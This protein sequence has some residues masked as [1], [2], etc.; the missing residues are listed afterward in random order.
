[1]KHKKLL[2]ITLVI[3]AL[4]IGSTLPGIAYN[5]GKS[6]VQSLEVV[7]EVFD[8][9]DWVDSI[10][11]NFGDLVEFKITIT[12]H[13]VTAPGTMHWAESIVVT[14]QLPSCLD[15][16][17]CS[18]TPFEPTIVGKTLEWDLGSIKLMDGES[19]VITFN[20]TVVEYGINVNNAK[21]T[22]YEHCT[23][24][25]IQGKDTATVNVI[26][27]NAE[28]DVKKFVT[29]NECDWVKD[30][31][32]GSGET[33][34]FKIVI[35]NI[36]NVDLT[37]IV[38][39]DTLSDSL[40]YA[41]DATPE[42]P[43]INGKTLTWEFPLLEV[44][45]VIEIEFDA[46]V[47]GLAC[48][49]D[50]NHV[51]V[52]GDGVCEQD[53]TDSDEV[54]IRIKG[55]CMEK[56]V[57]DNDLHAWMEETDAAVGET[58]RFR[59]RV[60]YH[61]DMTLKQIQVKDELP[62]CLEYADNA[63][64]IE[65]DVSGHTLWWNF[66]S[67][68]NIGNGE[69]LIIEFDAEVYQNNCQPCENW[70]YAYA[71]ECGINEMYW[72][73]PATV[74]I[75]CAFIADAGG[76][77][78]GDIEEDITI[79]GSATGGNP[80]YIYEWDL[81]DDGIYGALEDETGKVT[82]FYWMESGNYDIHLRVTDDDNKK[83]YDHTIVT[84]APGENNPPNKPSTPTGQSHGT[85]GVLYEYSTSTTD[86]DGDQVMYLFDWGDGTNSGWLG[87][88]DSGHVCKASHKWSYGSF[89]IKV[90]AR[91]THFDESVF[92]DPLSISMPRVKNPVI[93]KIFENFLD[94]YPNIFPILR[95][96]LGL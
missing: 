55:M 92:S 63:I 50:I 33:V 60:M 23:G 85:I 69:T 6:N 35:E 45:Q 43:D 9:V 66:S 93:I 18:A 96:I 67:A 51:D 72:E 90:K 54:I 80:P 44:D 47:V 7:K 30:I 76:P 65:P 11:A 29:I 95:Q 42:E 87:P 59:I 78:S 89:S 94:R 27:P 1:M 22:A 91:D 88:Y 86:P 70:A 31:W 16:V 34:R 15:Y 17:L 10:D 12:Y 39:T 83:A 20:A 2:V 49:V 79:T 73:D 37:D 3:S 46:T 25:T 21:A 4:L 26:I 38:V 62:G 19:Y 56:E 77:Y 36:G 24:L 13:N 8:G 28:I 48:S 40:E 61:G 82:K 57:Y 58:V 74:N 14:D 41:D 68:Y 75:D 71:M 32:A 5:I 53:A 81:D 64:P 84:I 52:V